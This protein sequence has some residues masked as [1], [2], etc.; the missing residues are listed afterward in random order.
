[1][2][3]ELNQAGTGDHLGDADVWHEN[4][5]ESARGTSGQPDLTEAAA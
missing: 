4:P 2:A 1:M 5:L 3:D